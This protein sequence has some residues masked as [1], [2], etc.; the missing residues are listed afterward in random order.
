[1]SVQRFLAR[2]LRRARMLTQVTD[3]DVPM[4]TLLWQM[5]KHAA[6]MMVSLFLSIASI[7]LTSLQ[8][9]EILQLKISVGKIS[10]III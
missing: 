9:H 4:D 3:V 7:V 10:F 5:T 6:K 1:M 2:A 8:C